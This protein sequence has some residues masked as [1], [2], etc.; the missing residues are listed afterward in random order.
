MKQLIYGVTLLL[1]IAGM[2]PRPALAQ[3][4]NPYVGE[5]QIFAFNFC[6]KG[7]S[8]LQGQLL[9][10]S[11]NMV[12]FNLL[13]TTYGGDGTSNFALPKWGPI[14]TANGAALTACISLF[15]VFP[16]QH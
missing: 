16:S 7:W 6:P 12:L 8:T 15:G 5:I 4:T 14:I 10:I 13:G 9:P 11:Q 3:A 1:S 2:A